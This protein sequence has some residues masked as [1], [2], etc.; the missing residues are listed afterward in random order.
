MCCRSLSAPNSDA[1]VPVPRE[2]LELSAAIATITSKQKLYNES[3]P[4][5]IITSA[6]KRWTPEL[7][8]D[9]PHDPDSY[10]PM[11]LYK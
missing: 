1:S 8:P 10:F 3:V 4:P 11:H 6:F 5:P 9:A 2:P 7:A